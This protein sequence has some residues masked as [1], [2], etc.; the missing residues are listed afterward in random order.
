MNTPALPLPQTPANA[1]VASPDPSPTLDSATLLGGRKQV[2]I[3]H[4]G[5]LYS[6]RLTRNG[7]LILTK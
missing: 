4:G 3:S 7:K 6:L 2:A 1:S 5:E